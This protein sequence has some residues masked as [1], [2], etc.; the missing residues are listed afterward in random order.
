MLDRY[1][2]QQLLS[3]FLLA[4]T[5]LGCLMSTGFVLF[6]LIEESARF[7]Y[8]LYLI[9][10]VFALRLPEMLY[11]TL[12][13]AIL[14]GSMLAVARLAADHEWLT[15]RLLGW[16][17]WRLLVPFVG[18]ACAAV[19]L[20]VVLNETLVPSGNF[21]A[22]T[23]LTA[24]QHDEIRLPQDQDHLFLRETDAEGLKHLIYAHKA[25]EGVL[26][27]VVIQ[28]FEAHQ[29]RFVIQAKEA[30]LEGGVWRFLQGRTLT[31]D[32]QWSPEQPPLQATF[33]E[34]QFPLSQALPSFLA[35]RRQPQEMNARDLY[36]HIQTLQSLG[37]N[38]RALQV[39]WQQ[40]F[41]L[42]AA[43]IPFVFLGVI[44]GAR[45]VRSR[46][47]GLGLSLVL[48]FG[49]YLLMS[50][51]T[52]MGDSGQWPPFWAAW[53]P[54]LVLMPIVLGLVQWRNQRG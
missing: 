13:M 15:L 18:F 20:S 31:L 32:S 6:G 9:V 3:P 42:P 26:Y 35:E 4:L 23:L 39:R 41:A 29:L 49:Y 11:Y 22:R 51:G 33:D 27:D 7:Q 17:F 8:P 54:H 38:T 36:Q 2:L 30:R 44:L 16:S 46:S 19:I 37:Q 34:Y 45:T 5:L 48:V 24:A 14:M 52:A 12:P 40:K 53:L 43:A 25:R 28:R 50:L 1:L 21:W 47:Q 10:K